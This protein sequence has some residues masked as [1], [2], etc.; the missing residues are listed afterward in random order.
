MANLRAWFD[1]AIKATGD[2]PDDLRILIAYERHG[3]YSS[4]QEIA[5]DTL[6]TFEFD[7]GFGGENG[8]QFMAWS[9]NYVYFK[10]IYD[11]AETLVWVPAVFSSNVDLSP[12]GGW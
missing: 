7:D 6:P 10:Q 4:K 9:K 5:Y 11:G 12:I 1:D 8:P 2:K 3:E